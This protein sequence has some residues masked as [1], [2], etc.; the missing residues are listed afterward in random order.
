MAQFIQDTHLTADDLVLNYDDVTRMFRNGEVAMY[1]GT[2]A[3]VKMFRD[4]G[5]NTIFSALLQ[6]ERR[7][8]WIMTTPISKL[9]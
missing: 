4:Q 3:G 9:P 8:P 6:P 1:F 7:K 2:S 5:I